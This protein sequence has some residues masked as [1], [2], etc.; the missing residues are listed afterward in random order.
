MPENLG[1]PQSLLHSI[2]VGFV[3]SVETTTGPGSVN[4]TFQAFPQSRGGTFA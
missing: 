2:G 3:T 4:R 1:S